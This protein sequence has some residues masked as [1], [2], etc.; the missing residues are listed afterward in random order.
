MSDNS[1]PSFLRWICRP[2]EIFLI[3]ILHWVDLVHSEGF[4]SHFRCKELTSI[5]GDWIWLIGFLRSVNTPQTRS[6]GWGCSV[7]F[8]FS[9]TCESMDVK[10]VSY[11]KCNNLNGNLLSPDIKSSFTL[12]TNVR[13]LKLH[14][15]VAASQ[16]SV[17]HAC[18]LFSL[19]LR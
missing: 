16:C 3:R 1:I 13:N 6:D 14:R 19:V 2:G 15:P 5:S 11:L 7:F 10:N 4:E 12:Q 17:L 8:F 9:F 18:F